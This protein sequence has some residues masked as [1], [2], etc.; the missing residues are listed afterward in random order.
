MQITCTHCGY[1]KEI[2]PAKL[3]AK[4][5]KVKCPKCKEIFPLSLSE[6]K[7]K[8]PVKTVPQAKVVTPVTPVTFQPQSMI[9]S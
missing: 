1:N 2:D 5:T 3:P 6:P 7:T 8:A 9:F 4:I